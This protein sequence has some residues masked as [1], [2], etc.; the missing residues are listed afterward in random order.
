MEKQI[1]TRV[2]A[3]TGY[4]NIVPVVDV[5]YGMAPESPA[6]AYPDVLQGLQCGQSGR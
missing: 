3:L 2:L 4:T 1:Y 5:L 6:L